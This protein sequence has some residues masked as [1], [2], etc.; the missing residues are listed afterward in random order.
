MTEQDSKIV[1]A[2]S[3]AARKAAVGVDDVDEAILKAREAAAK[4]GFDMDRTPSTE[5]EADRAAREHWGLASFAYRLEG[6]ESAVA[7]TTV[8]EELNGR[9][10]RGGVL[11]RHGVDLR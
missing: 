5:E 4:A 1:P 11:H 8:E 10:G 6:L 7:A 9:A 3:R 2:S